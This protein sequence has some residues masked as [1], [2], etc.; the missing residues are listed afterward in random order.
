MFNIGDII[1]DMKI[2]EITKDKYYRK[3]C[4]VECVKCGRKKDMIAS[5]LK[6]RT[7]T[8]HKACGKGLK[9]KNKFFYDRWQAMR[10]RTTNPNYEHWKDYGG[11]GINSDEF[12]LF[13]DFYDAMYESFEEMGKQIGYE[14]T[15]LER[16]NVDGNYSKDNCK[17]IHI[18]DQKG[19]QRK[20]VSFIAENIHTK[21]KIK[22]RNLTRFCKNFQL[23]R[24]CISDVMNGKLPMY[25][26][27]VVK[28]A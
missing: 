2:I 8:T 5:T 9:T 15:S 13:I 11:R 23:N 12:A 4:T 24:S 22:S 16:I 6:R 1:D 7:G 10:T 26:G 28:R 19:N 21:E 3:V 27:W 14:N 18:K 17:W 20:T 25:K